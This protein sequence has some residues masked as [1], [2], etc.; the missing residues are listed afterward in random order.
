M[1][2][3]DHEIELIQK[4]I[5]HLDA[6]TCKT[7]SIWLLEHIELLET[8]EKLYHVSIQQLKLSTRALNMLLNNQITT[9]GQ[10][11]KMSA[12]WD[13]IR[14]LKGAGEKV[15]NE[16]REKLDELQAGNTDSSPT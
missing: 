2:K 4:S 1:N 8:D 15:L 5:Q 9:I 10:L 13:S 12:D 16:L 7:I 3:Q 11:V 6:K 14:Q